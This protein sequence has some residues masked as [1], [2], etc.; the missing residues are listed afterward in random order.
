MIVSEK[1]R[2]QLL[3]EMFKAACPKLWALM[4]YPWE[5]STVNGAHRFPKNTHIVAAYAEL[6]RISRIPL[7]GVTLFA[8][9][10]CSATPQPT[11][12][13]DGHEE[14]PCDGRAGERPPHPPA[15]EVK[16]G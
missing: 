13:D 4:N 11:G 1:Q 14:T 16:D 7:P 5:Y 3:Q 10:D 2:E 15:D 6:Q 8:H 9:D 12:G